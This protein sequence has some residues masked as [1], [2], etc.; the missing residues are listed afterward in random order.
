M[1]L[2]V[3]SRYQ[4]RSVIYQV[5]EVIDLPDADARALL[6]DSPGSFEAVTKAP[7]EAPEVKALDAPPADKMIRRAPRTKGGKS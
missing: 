4:A 1:K 3:I 7:P 6:A 2:R 5:G